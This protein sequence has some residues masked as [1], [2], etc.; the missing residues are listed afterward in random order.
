MVFGALEWRIFHLGDGRLFLENACVLFYLDTLW[1]FR[2]IDSVL[3]AIFDF[4]YVV[5]RRTD[6]FQGSY[7]EGNHGNTR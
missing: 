2:D 3:M 1:F 6:I 5:N 7:R 4:T